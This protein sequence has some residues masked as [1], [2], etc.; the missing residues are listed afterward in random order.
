MPISTLDPLTPGA[1]DNAGLGDDKIREIKQALVDCF[2]GVDGLV[3]AGAGNGAA[4]AAELTSLFDSVAILVAASNRALFVGDIRMYYGTFA[5][6]PAGW[7][8]CDGTG[9]TPDMRG[10]LPIGADNISGLPTK[11]GAAAGG[12]VSGATN[13]GAQSGMTATVGSHTLTLAELP[14]G[15]N[16]GISVA[17][18]TGGD[19]IQHNQTYGAAGGEGAAGD[20]T[21]PIKVPGALGSGH[22]HPLSGTLEHTHSIPGGSLPPW[23]SV[24]FIMYTG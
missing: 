16:G 6:I 19:G 15:L 20:Y 10:L 13:T 7:R 23:K 5:S 1:N 24:F 22:T 21:A 12:S 4:T 8:N 17:I 14:A 11:G 3:E 2:G 18:T 9:G